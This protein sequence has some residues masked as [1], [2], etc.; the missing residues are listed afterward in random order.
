MIGFLISNSS[1][2]D[3][4]I[5]R[6]AEEDVDIEIDRSVK[7]LLMLADCSR[8]Q[9]FSDKDTNTERLANKDKCSIIKGMVCLIGAI[10]PNALIP[11]V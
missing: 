7:G 3:P 1:A 2:K 8:G 11:E 4:N 6:S 10:Y 5:K 9:K